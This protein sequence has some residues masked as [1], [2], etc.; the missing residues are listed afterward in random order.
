[1]RKSKVRQGSIG[2]PPLNATG[3]TNWVS[4]VGKAHSGGHDADDPPRNAVNAD[5]L[6]DHIRILPKALLPVSVTQHHH[7]I[8]S[9]YFLA[10]G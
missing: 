7:R 1:M 9:G 5:G 8:V 4:R 6:P 10:P 2:S 3:V